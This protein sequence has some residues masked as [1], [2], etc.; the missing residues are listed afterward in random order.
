M[1][2]IPPHFPSYSVIPLLFSFLLTTSYLPTFIKHPHL[3]FILP[4]QPNIHP[5]LKQPFNFTF[6]SHLFPFIPLSIIPLP[7][8]SPLSSPHLI[9][10]LLI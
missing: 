3:V 6:I 5:Y 1:N 7:L 10:Y 2:H 9:L 8:Y 4:F